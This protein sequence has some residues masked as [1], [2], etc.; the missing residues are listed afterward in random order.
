VRQCSAERPL[1]QRIIALAAAYAVAL[2]SLFAS[3]GLARAAAATPAVPGAVICHTIVDADQAPSPASDH[4][5][6]CADNCSRGCIMHVAALPPPPATPAG[7]LQSAAQRLPP[8]AVACLAARPQ[9]ASHRSR[10]PPSVA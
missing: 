6:H 9:T 1:R 10:A 2:S 5:D 4:A 7:V 3:Y 8:A